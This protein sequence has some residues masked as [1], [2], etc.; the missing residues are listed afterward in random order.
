MLEISGVVIFF[1]DA[2]LIYIARRND[3]WMK[4]IRKGK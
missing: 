3:R 2:I 1:F 4:Q